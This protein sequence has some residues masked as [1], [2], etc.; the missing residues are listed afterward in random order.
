MKKGTMP[1]DIAE[2]LLEL[3]QSTVTQTGKAVNQTFNPLQMLEGANNKESLANPTTGDKISPENIPNSSKLDVKSLQDKYNNQD[4]LKLTAMR[5]RL[6][7]LVK[8]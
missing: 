3:G 4:S 6:F 8:E 2:T 5:S 1:A 7:K